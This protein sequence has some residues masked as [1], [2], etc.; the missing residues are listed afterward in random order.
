MASSDPQPKTVDRL[1]ADIDRGLTGEKVPGSD[2]AAAPMGTD[3]EAGGAAP[4]RSEI[5]LEAR[6]RPAPAS[7]TPQRSRGWLWVAG[8]LV[9]LLLVVAVSAS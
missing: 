5:D 8:V 7:P 4:T 2:P 3:A 9:L 6:S 1:R